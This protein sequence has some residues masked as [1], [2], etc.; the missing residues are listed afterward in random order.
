MVA[1]PDEAWAFDQTYQLALATNV[2][3]FRA[4]VD[5]QKLFDVVD[6]DALRRSGAIALVV[7]DGCF[8]KRAVA[9]RPLVL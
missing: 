3:Q 9:V 6:T 2:A 8:A 4:F 5:G 1:G 7:E